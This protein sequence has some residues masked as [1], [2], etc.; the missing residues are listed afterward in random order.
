MFACYILHGELKVRLSKT[1]KEN[2]TGFFDN[3]DC[4]SSQSFIEHINYYSKIFECDAKNVL[5]GEVMKASIYGKL[6]MLLGAMLGIL[7]V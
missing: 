7:F 4:V 5:Q 2:L 1:Q 3:L 6:G